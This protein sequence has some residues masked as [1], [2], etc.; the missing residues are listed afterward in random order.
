LLQR[1][2]WRLVSI[3]Q[4]TQLGLVVRIMVSA[5]LQPITLSLI[6]IER[7]QNRFPKGFHFSEA[8]TFQ[9]AI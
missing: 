1:Q 5:A 4:I 6:G 9:Y 8:L 3:E 2:I 7:I